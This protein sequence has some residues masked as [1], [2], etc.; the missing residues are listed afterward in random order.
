MIDLEIMVYHQLSPEGA[1]FGQQLLLSA[2]HFPILIEFLEPNLY[3]SNSESISHHTYESR[4]L[5]STRLDSFFHRLLPDP[6]KEN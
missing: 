5:A 4:K 1:H 3:I 6:T 2:T